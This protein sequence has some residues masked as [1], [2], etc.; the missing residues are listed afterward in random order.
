MV[1]KEH[2][3]LKAHNKTLL[4]YDKILGA[5]YFDTETEKTNDQERDMFKLRTDLK[6]ARLR[7]IELQKEVTLYKDKFYSLEYMLSENKE[8]V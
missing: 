1:Y 7:I 6:K 8:A 3:S 4:V 5:V 2:P